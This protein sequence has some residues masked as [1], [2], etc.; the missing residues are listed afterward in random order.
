MK[1]KKTGRIMANVSD[2]DKSEFERIAS[3]L[4]LSSAGL[5]G[6]L[7][8][9]FLESKRKYGNQ[10]FYPPK[11]HT[12]ESIKIQEEIDHEDS[13]NSVSQQKAG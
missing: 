1:D 4:R 7:I 13:E 8:E 10:L 12:F 9:S 11:F 6:I 3:E 5:A 2:S